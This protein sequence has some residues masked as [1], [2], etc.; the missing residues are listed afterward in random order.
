MDPRI[1]PLLAG[2]RLDHFAM[3]VQDIEKAV[4]FLKPILP[5]PFRRFEFNSTSKIYGKVSSYTLG[6]A[7]ASL[8]REVNLEIIQT[9][10]GENEVHARFLRERG[11]GIEHFGY[12]VDDLH[13]SIH[14]FEKA[15]FEVILIKHGAAP[16]SVYLDTTQ[17]GGTITELV[18]KGFKPDDPSTWPK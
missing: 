15:G 8:S 1:A 12:E 14:A 13:A 3:V 18:Q 2:A 4:A 7:L 17:I 9:T 10:A 16:G 11:E 6:I 5:G